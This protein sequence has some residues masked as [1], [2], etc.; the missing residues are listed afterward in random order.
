MFV[1]CEKRKGFTL[2][3]MVLVV[4]VIS[5]LAMIAVQRISRI[6]SD[7][8]IVAA[9][10][11]MKMIRDA[12]VSE[13]T[14]YLRDMSGIPGFSSACLRIGNLFVATNVFGNKVVRGSKWGTETISARLDC[15]NETVEQC[16]A[17][18]RAVP[19]AFVKWDSAGRR[20]WRGPYLSSGKTGFFPSKDGVRFAGDATFE[21]RN[22][23]PVLLNLRL[24][25]EFK[26]SSKAS[27]YGFAG[28][29]VVFDPWGNPYVLQIP[30]P[31]AFSSVT[32]VSDDV[33]FSYAR[34]VSAGPDGILSTPCFHANA[35]NSYW[36]TWNERN[37]RMSRQAG[38]VDGTDFSARGDDLVLFLVRTDIDEGEEE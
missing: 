24:P 27:V 3:E 33:R 32:N 23:Y 8:R 19:S 37:R 26:D 13:E 16:A 10:S 18:R 15:G 2:V 11:D 29:P 38:L 17:E 34:V 31:Q 4:A 36:T 22:F 7:A 35:T 9:K 1:S 30:P 21:E 28:E 6:A 20:G 14:G 12:F 25:E 5:I